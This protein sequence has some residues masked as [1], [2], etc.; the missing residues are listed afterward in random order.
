MNQGILIILWIFTTMVVL[1]A[2]QYIGIVVMFAITVV[3]LFA[4]AKFDDKV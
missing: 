3:M 1:A 4:C 2:F